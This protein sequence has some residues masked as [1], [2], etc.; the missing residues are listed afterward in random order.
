MTMQI[1]DIQAF[2]AVIH[3]KNISRAAEELFV[4]QSTITH[5]LKNLE[6]SMGV[7]LIDRGRGMKSL[8]LTP[9][10]EDFLLLAERWSAL[11]KATENLK[12]QGDQMAL[13]FGS[14]ESLNLCV[15]PPLFMSLEQ[16]IP[17]IRLEIHT[18]HTTDLYTWVER[19]QLD[20]AIVLRDIFSPNINTEPWISAPMVVLKTGNPAEAG[21]QTIQNT[22]LNTNSEIYVPWGPTFQQWHEQWWAPICPSRIKITGSTLIFTLLK[23]P[24]QWT[25]VPM[26]IAQYAKT[27]GTFTYYH[28][29]DPP[30]E[31][32]CYKIT[33]KFPKP[34][35]QR[36]LAVLNEYLNQVKLSHL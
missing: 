34:S 8:Y 27:L 35:T 30:P 28:L 25:V 17:K 14:V 18:Q 24:E 19:R 36:S 3:N 5:R 22:T 20:M 10:G 16:H 31:I 29:S 15:F 13:S 2:L 6:S 33:H 32:V 26:W 12:Q 23:N 1:H 4:S 21:Q 7:T 9:A 11:W